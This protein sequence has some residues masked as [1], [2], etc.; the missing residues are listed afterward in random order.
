MRRY[1]TDLEVCHCDCHTMEGVHHVVTCCYECPTC[2]QNI[3]RA[4][5]NDHAQRCAEEREQLLREIE[6]TI[7]GIKALGPGG[8][9]DPV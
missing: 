1:L 2:G 8:V 4:S 3:H 7:Q 9:G 5:F 6:E